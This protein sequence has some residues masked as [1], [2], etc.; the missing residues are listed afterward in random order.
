MP[1]FPMKIKEIKELIKKFNLKN[2]LT[3]NFNIW[4]GHAKIGYRN[5][6]SIE[7][8]KEPLKKIFDEFIPEGVPTPENLKKTLSQW[9]NF[10]PYQHVRELDQPMFISKDNENIFVAVIW[11]WQFKKGVASLMLYQGKVLD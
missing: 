2:D 1:Y 9:E 11:P 3:Q 10:H 5:R 8:T 6:P 7:E 4:V